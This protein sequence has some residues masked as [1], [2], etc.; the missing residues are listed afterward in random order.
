MKN[1][2]ENIHKASRKVPNI[3]SLSNGSYSCELV[4]TIY[5]ADLS[6][7]EKPPYEFQAERNL[8]Q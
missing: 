8:T 4:V 6:G 2:Q 3:V 7:K 5:H 1:K